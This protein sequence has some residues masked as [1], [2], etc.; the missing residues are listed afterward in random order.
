M[1]IVE[2]PSGL[3]NLVSN[4]RQSSLCGFDSHKWQIL[5]SCFDMI[6]AVEQDV[7]P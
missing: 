5:K 1:W 2:V 6:L 7:K 3:V 4:H